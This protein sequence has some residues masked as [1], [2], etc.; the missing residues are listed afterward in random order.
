MMVVNNPLIRPYFLGGGGDW[1][2]TLRFPW[3]YVAFFLTKG[4]RN[5]RC[6]IL[7]LSKIAKVEIPAMW[8]G[9]LNHHKKTGTQTFYYAK[10]PM[11]GVF[12]YISFVLLGK[13]WL[14]SSLILGWSLNLRYT[15]I[16]S[17]IFV[18]N[19]RFSPNNPSPGQFCPPCSC[20]HLH[21]D[22]EQ[23]CCFEGICCFNNMN[24]CKPSPGCQENDSLSNQFSWD[25]SSTKL[26]FPTASTPEV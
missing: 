10:D 13:K 6:F 16:G 5:T 21:H 2:D 22:P 18:E 23:V 9:M 1:G 26:P 14:F 25:F 19:P 15:H 24:S 4:C 11:Y 7:L 17:L 12:T 20:R 8:W 3:F